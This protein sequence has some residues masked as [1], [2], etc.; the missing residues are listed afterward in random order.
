[1]RRLVVGIILAVVV[2]V[3][4]YTFTLY[5]KASINRCWHTIDRAEQMEA[6]D[7]SNI[8]ITFQDSPMVLLVSSTSAYSAGPPI[9]RVEYR[10]DPGRPKVIQLR[11]Y[12]G[13]DVRPT[14]VES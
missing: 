2:A 8:M 12:S 4:I 14:E 3:S 9:V 5:K 11:I 10:K 7:H 13:D 6:A 1:M